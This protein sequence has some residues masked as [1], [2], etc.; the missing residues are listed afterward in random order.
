MSATVLEL[1][2]VAA[3]APATGEYLSPS[4]ASTYLGC[5]AKWYFRYMFGLPDPA[6]GGAVRGKA[7]HQ[8]IEYALAAK[9]AGVALGPADLADAWDRAWDIA[10]EGAEFQQ[11]DDIEALK[12]SGAR[13]TH[14]WIHEAAPAV[15][16]AAVEQPFAGEIAGVRVRGIADI[17]TTDGMVIDLKTSSR[18][19]NGISADHALQLATYAALVPGASG[20]TRIDTLIGTK[21][22]Q[23]VQIGHAP[24]AAGRRLVEKMYPLVAEGIR[25][26]L[27]APNRSSPLCSRRYCNF[28]DACEREFGGV[29]E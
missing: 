21:E 20:E 25:G 17:V 14:K 5:Q 18:K 22:P 1:V 6:G 2:P 12:G 10:A 9:M 15:Q 3:P 11:F 27:Y 24:G 7:V 16:P 28:A 29:V 26:G 19:P 8:V 13:L 23:L 4:Q